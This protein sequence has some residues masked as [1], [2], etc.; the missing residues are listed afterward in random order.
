MKKFVLKIHIYF[1][2]W[3]KILTNFHNFQKILLFLYCK[4]NLLLQKNPCITYVV[5]VIKELNTTQEMVSAAG[6]YVLV[7][8]LQWTTKGIFCIRSQPLDTIKESSTAALSNCAGYSLR[9]FLEYIRRTNNGWKYE[10]G[11]K[12]RCKKI[13]YTISHSIESCIHASA[14]KNFQWNYMCKNKK[15][16]CSN[17]IST[18][19]RLQQHCSSESRWGWWAR[20]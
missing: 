3:I 1:N 15:I 14:N 9:T 20:P 4:N 11:E 6:N 5:K 10:G 13:N 2:V 8:C 17:Y 18:M 19:R 7:L 16:C 12:Q